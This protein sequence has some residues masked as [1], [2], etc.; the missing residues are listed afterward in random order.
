[1]LAATPQEGLMKAAISTD[2]RRCRRVRPSGGTGK[3]GGQKSKTGRDD[4]EP[5]N[6]QRALTFTRSLLA[7]RSPPTLSLYL[8]SRAVKF[9]YVLSEIS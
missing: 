3:A 2:T 8:V 7:L 9:S 4:D 6:E 1:M 5:I